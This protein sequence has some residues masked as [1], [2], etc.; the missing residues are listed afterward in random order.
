MSA[1]GSSQAHPDRQV[2]V[3]RPWM[4][5]ACGGDW[6]SAVLLSQVIWWSQASER[7]G[8]PRAGYVRDGAHWLLRTDDDGEWWEECRLKPPQVKR[9]KGRLVAAGLIVT[10]RVKWAGRP[11]AAVRADFETIAK[12]AEGEEPSTFARSYWRKD[13]DSTEFVPIEG[14]DQIRTN[15][16]ERIRTD[17]RIGTNSVESLYLSGRPEVLETSFCAPTP[18][19]DWE[20]SLGQSAPSGARQGAEPDGFAEFYAAYPRKKSRRTAATAYAKARKRATAA[21]ILTGLAMVVAGWKA[22]GRTMEHTPY[23]ASWLNADG[24]LDEPDAAA[25]PGRRPATA[26]GRTQGAAFDEQFAN[27]F[28]RFADQ[29]ATPTAKEITA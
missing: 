24:W 3:V 19:G 4:V 11:V 23:P 18:P 27:V 1:H 28:G 13:L 22:S 6:P 9:A 17:P 26:S 15:G 12:V 8:K 2:I 29:D 5:D 25:T 21:E 16:S 20:R 7:T 14:S 10:M